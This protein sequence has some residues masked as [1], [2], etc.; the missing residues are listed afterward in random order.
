MHDWP[1]VDCSM[2][3]STGRCPHDERV[4]LGEAKGDS[5]GCKGY[6]KSVSGAICWLDY[7]IYENGDVDVCAIT[8]FHD[9]DVLGK[10][11]VDF[12]G[13]AS[14]WY[15]TFGRLAIWNGVLLKI[16]FCRMCPLRRGCMSLQVIVKN[17]VVL[18]KCSR[19]GGSVSSP[20]IC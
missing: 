2:S 18:N 14:W 8:E 10:D 15:G 6:I 1:P 7:L 20:Y 4:E 12:F 9:F 16:C 17:I 3:W 13:I 19:S 11:S 5:N